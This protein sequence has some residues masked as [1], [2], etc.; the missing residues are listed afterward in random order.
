MLLIVGT[1]LVL[2]TLACSVPGLALQTEEETQSPPAATHTVGAGVAGEPTQP[3]LAPTEPPSQEPAATVPP[4][5][6][7]GQWAV[8]ATAS[9]EYSTPDWSA[10]QATAAPDTPECGDLQTAW[11]SEASDGVDWLEVGYATPV[12]PSQINIYETNSPGFIVRVE[13]RDQAGTYYTVWEGKPGPLE[14]CPRVLSIPV[15]E[16][17]PRVVAVRIS[18]DQ[19]PGGDWDEIDAVQLVGRP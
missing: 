4:A 1:L 3:A 5:G 15:S 2:L 8:T 17:E 18:L 11:A 10:Q 6:E 19:R 16:V 9:S 14:Q 13:V 12:R 7:M